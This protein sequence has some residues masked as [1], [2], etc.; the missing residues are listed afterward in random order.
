MATWAP[1]QRFFR[2]SR[3]NTS[4]AFTFTT[5]RRS[6]SRPASKFR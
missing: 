4:A 5:I 3:R 1:V 6:K 2:N